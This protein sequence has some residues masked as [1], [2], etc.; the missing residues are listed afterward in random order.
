M[1]MN[2]WRRKSRL[3]PYFAWSTVQARRSRQS[4]AATISEGR[5]AR[6]S[7]SW[8]RKV[9]TRK[10]AS[11]PRAAITYKGMGRWPKAFSA[12][13]SSPS[14]GA[15]AGVRRAPSVMVP[16]RLRRNSTRATSAK[17]P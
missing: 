5:R 8:V 7:R 17:V 15:P 14:G 1:K 12:A 16:H 10:K 4:T 11:P 3:A 6:R 13:L 2:T 9:P